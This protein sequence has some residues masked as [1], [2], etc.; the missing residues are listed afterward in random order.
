MDIFVNGTRKKDL[1]EAKTQYTSLIVFASWDEIEEGFF[2]PPKGFLYDDEGM[3]L[4]VHTKLDSLQGVDLISISEP[5]FLKI[6][7]KP[8]EIQLFLT[9]KK[10][11]IFHDDIPVIELLKNR[12]DRKSDSDYSTAHIVY[13]FFNL[14]T[15]NDYNTLVKMEEGISKLEDSILAN[16]EKNYSRKISI[17]RKRLLTCKRY[18]ESLLTLLDDLNENENGIF[19]AEQLRSMGLIHN[20]V[21]RLFQ[22]VQSLRDYVTQVR[23]SYQSQMD[24]SLN[25]TMRIFTV[26]TFIFSPLTLIVGWYGMNLRMPELDS[27]F[28]YPVIIIL[29]L[30]III[31]SIIYFKKR[32]WF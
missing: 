26:V 11:Y 3:R 22:N 4:P 14:L 23:E 1:P 28:T 7:S 15:K 9:G 27:S 8:A 25:N 5:N 30:A 31:G 32:K 16:K 29:S 2:V 24:I 20:R 17:L 6:R 10:L 12:L 21:E 18:Y 19:S 13:H